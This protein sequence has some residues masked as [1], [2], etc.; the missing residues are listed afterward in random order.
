LEKAIR[1][2]KELEDRIGIVA[3]PMQQNQFSQFVELR[4]K[5][6]Q[7]IPVRIFVNEKELLSINSEC[8]TM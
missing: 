4:V 3:E 7:G 2:D 8:N 1:I 5:V 6:P